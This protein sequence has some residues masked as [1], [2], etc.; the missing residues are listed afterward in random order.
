ME[1]LKIGLTC[2]DLNGIG[3]EVII[4]TF[5]DNRMLE[6]CTPIVYASKRT[7]AE[8]RRLLDIKDFSFEEIPSVQQANPKRAC[9]LNVWNEDVQL[10]LGTPT[11]DSGRFARLSLRAAVKDLKEGHIDAIVTAPID[12]KNI[13]GDGF[14]YPGHT[15]FLAAE[16]GAEE[17]AM[18]ML[19]DQLRITFM[20]GHVPLNKVTE[21]LTFERLIKRIRFID[22][23]FPADFGI[24][25]PRI[26][27]L[28]LNP[29]N[30]DDGVIG[31]EEREIILPAIRK[32][33][34]DGLMVF[35]PFAADGFFGS[36]AFR[37]YD[38][39]LAMYHDQGLIPFKTMNFENGM[40]Y[41]AG[42]SHVRTSPDHGTAFDI[43]GQGIASEAS[44]R[45]A[46]FAAIDLVR[47][48]EDHAEWSADPLKQ[49]DLRKLKR[50]PGPGGPGK[51]NK[52]PQPH[53]GRPA[54]QNHTAPSGTQ[55]PEPD[56][57]EADDDIE[58]LEG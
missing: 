16:F 17:H 13:Q 6:L 41:T 11:A 23:I 55:A 35:G 26:A 42:L 37:Q 45:D 30:G 32:A 18:I 39:V 46:V 38:V 29:H 56:V 47:A 36:G 14:N 22:R 3:L 50:P 53:Q 40:N 10:Q 2:G 44:L 54:P 24:V 12:K 8:Y 19:S 51:G 9:V 57:E 7:T 49:V 21:G 31:T 34:D 4:K 48:R 28:G 1:K 43:A 52:G 27:V 5:M 58:E 33:K 15:E 25:R 20:T